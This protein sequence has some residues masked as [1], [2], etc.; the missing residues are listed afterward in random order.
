[1]SALDLSLP[2]DKVKQ[3]AHLLET[4]VNRALNQLKSILLWDSVTKSSLVNNQLTL[5][6]YKNKIKCIYIF[7]FIKKGIFCILFHLLCRL[8]LQHIDFIHFKFVAFLIFDKNKPK[9]NAIQLIAHV[10]LFTLPKVYEVYKVQIDQAIQNASNS[11]HHL[12]R[13]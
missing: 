5:K 13:E 12:V 11:V 3:L 4:D 2:K 6:I 9:F 1:L 10:S 8:C 7:L